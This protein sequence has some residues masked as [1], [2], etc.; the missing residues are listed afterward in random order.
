MQFEKVDITGGWTVEF[1]PPHFRIVD[2]EGNVRLETDLW[3][4]KSHGPAED[5]VFWAGAIAD[6]TSGAFTDEVE[7]KTE[8]GLMVIDVQNNAPEHFADECLILE[9]DKEGG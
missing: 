2:D 3:E 5:A 8:F 1:F 6:K 4:P 7:N 9:L